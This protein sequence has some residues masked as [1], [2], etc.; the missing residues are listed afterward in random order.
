MSDGVKSGHYKTLSDTWSTTLDA[1]DKDVVGISLSMKS[2]ISRYQGVTIPF[3]FHSIPN[4]LPP[5]LHNC[6]L[7]T[8]HSTYS[9]YSTHQVPNLNLHPLCSTHYGCSVSS[10]HSTHQGLPTTLT[11]IS[12]MHSDPYS[13][14]SLHPANRSYNRNCKFCPQEVFDHV[15]SLLICGKSV[16]TRAIFSAVLFL[17][18]IS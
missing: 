12:T 15:T 5:S 13:L 2:E 10:A 18:H 3:I 6:N 7:H 1:M 14:N 9:A 17:T 16:I 4:V 8:L 11:E